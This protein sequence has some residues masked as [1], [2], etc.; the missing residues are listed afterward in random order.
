MI[1]MTMKDSDID[2]DSSENVW[3][4]VFSVERRNGWLKYDLMICPFVHESSMLTYE[5]H[6]V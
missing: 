3:T 5:L 4:T 2:D 1:T 6:L